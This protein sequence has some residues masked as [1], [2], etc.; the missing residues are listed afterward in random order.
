M[1]KRRY[2]IHS[3]PTVEQH[4]TI[5]LHNIQGLKDASKL[6]TILHIIKRDTLYAYCI[7]ETWIEGG[8]V[9]ELKDGAVFIHHGPTTQR[10][11]RGSGGV[12]I[13][14]SR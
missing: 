11:S 14:I 13:V 4:V 12:D 5:Q 6:E 3:S 2:K 10:S 1:R 9:Q 7:Q 8:Y